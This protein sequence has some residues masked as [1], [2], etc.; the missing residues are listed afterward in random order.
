MFAPLKSDLLASMSIL[1]VVEVPSTVKGN[2]MIVLIR[3]DAGIHDLGLM[4]RF[5]LKDTIAFASSYKHFRE[6]VVKP[7]AISVGRALKITD[8]N[9]LVTSNMGLHG[10]I[11]EIYIFNPRLPE[12]YLKLLQEQLKIKHKMEN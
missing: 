9:Q 3:S 1:A 2:E 8:D 7:I 12:G 11:M 10:K 6:S 4:P 5:A